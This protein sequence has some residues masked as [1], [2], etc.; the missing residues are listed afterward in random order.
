MSTRCKAG[1]LAIV[2]KEQPGYEGNLGRCVRVSGPEQGE[3]G[4]IV[5]Y[6]EPITQTAWDFGGEPHFI[7]VPGLPLFG[8]VLSDG[9][10]LP[11][12][13]RWVRVARQPSDKREVK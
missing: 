9:W 2:I 11:I 13:C 6:I 8:C 10:L 7:E 12:K 5:W 3:N 4:Q 1:G